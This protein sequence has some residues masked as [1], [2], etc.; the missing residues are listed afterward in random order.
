MIK[1]KWTAIFNFLILQTNA[2]PCAI[3]KGSP[4][5][6]RGVIGKY[7]NNNGFIKNLINISE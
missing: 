2:K 1:I 6:N 5:E 7:I 4:S 3:L